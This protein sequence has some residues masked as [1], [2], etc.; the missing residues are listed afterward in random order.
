MR[1]FRSDLAAPI[2]LEIRC[3]FLMK[4]VASVVL[5]PY[6]APAAPVA[7]AAK[8][9]THVPRKRLSVQRNTSSLTDTLP[10]PANRAGVSPGILDHQIGNA[11]ASQSWTA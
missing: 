10:S 4:G 1:A 7:C 2:L 8:K 6:R 9:K 11:G 5:L 3:G